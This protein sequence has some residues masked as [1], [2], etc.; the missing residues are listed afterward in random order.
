[1]LDFPDYI[2]VKSFDIISEQSHTSSTSISKVTIGR[3]LPGHLFAARMRCQVRPEEAVQT[4]GFITALQGDNVTFRYSD[5]L[6]MN[7]GIEPKTITS[8]ADK[9]DTFVEL[10]NVTGLTMGMMI[11]FDNHDKLYTITEIDGNIIVLN[12]RLVANVPQGAL[13]ISDGAE[14]V[15]ELV[16]ELKEA[17]QLSNGLRHDVPS[18][19]LRVQ[20]ALF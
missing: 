8:A 12:C 19:N 7:S 6:Y 20:E 16:P 17:S 15:F 3:N 13:F 1:M 2:I 9:G 5:P 11:N 18:F 4:L 10:N 14:G